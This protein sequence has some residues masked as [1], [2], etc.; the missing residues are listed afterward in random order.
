[1]NGVSVLMKETP[2]ASSP[3]PPVIIQ[4]KGAI[5]EPGGGISA[6][7]KSASVLILNFQPPELREMNVH[8]LSPPVSGILDVAA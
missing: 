4:V 1:M 6:D 5:Y 8:Y 7:T 3:L 2:R